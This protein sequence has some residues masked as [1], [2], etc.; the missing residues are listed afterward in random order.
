M[1]AIVNGIKTNGEKFNYTLDVTNVIYK[2]GN[3]IIVKKDGETLDYN[4]AISSGYK[5]EIEIIAE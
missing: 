4:E 5:Y 1:K 3:I 2:N